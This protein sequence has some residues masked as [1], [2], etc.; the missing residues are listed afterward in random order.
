M[1]IAI[2]YDRVNKWGGAERVLLTLHEMFPKAELFTSVYNS[3]KAFWANVFPK[4]HTSFIQNLPFAKDNHEYYPVLMPAAFESF[5]FDEFDL[6]ISVTSEAAKGIITKPGT[7]HICICLTPTRYLWS[8]YNHY[9]PN[10]IYK[11]LTSPV[12]SYLKKWDKVAA[13]RPDKLVAI[14]TEVQKRIQKYY[15]RDS[16]IIFPPV[17]IAKFT[18]Q[19]IS[20]AT[21][22]RYAYIPKDYFLV[23]SRLVPYKKVDLV[24]KTFNTISLSLVVVG[25]GKQR[26]KLI[27]MAN[28]NIIFP[29]MEVTDDESLAWFY[30]HCKA[31]IF[32]QDEDFGLTA[33]ECQ[34]FGKP[35]IA[36]KSGGALDTVLSGKTGIF[37]DQQNEKSLISALETFQKTKFNATLIS[38][39]AKRFSKENF[40]KGLLKLI[41]Q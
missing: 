14:S 23:V 38:Q 21:N 32:P 26:A 2:C 5:N 27:N 29:E 11:F 30:K 31:L 24:V 17:D 40:K 37:F 22:K 12:V 33:V 35:V 39:N 1:K 41:N 7:K 18:S 6:V 13:Y 8:G 25:K 19:K 34:V 15:H 9:F 4:I 28:K 10:K 3:D 36:Y 16:Q 20:S